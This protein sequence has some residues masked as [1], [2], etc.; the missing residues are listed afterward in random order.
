MKT[1][2]AEDR[3]GMTGEGAFAPHYLRIEALRSRQPRAFLVKRNPARWGEILGVVGFATDEE[4]ASSVEAA[5]A[6]SRSWSCARLAPRKTLLSSW[7]ADLEKRATVLAR[8][9]ALE[10]GK[11]VRL[12]QEEVRFALSLL[13]ALVSLMGRQKFEAWPS[14]KG[15]SVK[16]RPRG[17]VGIITPWNNPVSIPVGKIGAAVAFGN[18]VVWKAAPQ[19]PRTAGL[20]LEALLASGMPPG[21]VNLIFGEKRAAQKIIAHSRVA[22]VSFT[23]SCASGLEVSS[24]CGRLS[25]SA[26]LELGGNNGSL[27]MPGCDVEKAARELALSAFSFAGQRCTAPRRLI[28]HKRVYGSFRDALLESVRN[29]RVGDPTD[30]RTQLG[31]VISRKK[32]LELGKAVLKAKRAGASLLSGGD[33]PRDWRSGCF[34]EATVFESQTNDLFL[35]QQEMFGPIIVL[36]SAPDLE[37][38][39]ALLNG[40]KQGLAASLYSSDRKVQRRFLE[41]AECG[42]LKLNQTTLGTAPNVPFGGWKAS[43]LG[44]PEHDRGD[45][46]FYTRFQTLY[47]A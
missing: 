16:R 38:A 15:I 27:I 43:G 37:A 44:P 33:V 5:F 23:G 25:K 7:A 3:Y 20:V 42:V 18:T 35:V 34:F 39:L 45:V 29:L 21:L 30:I 12:G 6:A 8:T 24:L 17:V 47:C 31:P 2:P 10:I 1:L 19:A 41:E 46:E 11:P 14:P 28:V 9:M 26:Q 36:Q 40:V 13:H 4:I 32:Q 22:A